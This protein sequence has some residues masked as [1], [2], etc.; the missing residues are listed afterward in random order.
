MFR[1]GWVRSLIMINR[2]SYLEMH[3]RNRTKIDDDLFFFFKYITQ[4]DDSGSAFHLVSNDV[5]TFW[6]VMTSFRQRD[7]TKFSHVRISIQIA[8]PLRNSSLISNTEIPRLIKN[9]HM[10]VSRKQRRVIEPIS[11]REEQHM[12]TNLV[13]L[14]LT[15]RSCSEDSIMDNVQ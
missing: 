3:W 6:I 2:N 7:I 8:L 10:F 14:P 5:T 9:I 15:V 4:D 11:H 13:S 12:I 1:R